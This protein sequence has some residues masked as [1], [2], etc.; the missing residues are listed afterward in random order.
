MNVCRVLVCAASCWT[1]LLEDMCISWYLCRNQETLG[2]FSGVINKKPLSA[3][4]KGS[5][6]WAR[7]RFCPEVHAGQPLGAAFTPD[8]WLTRLV[9]RDGFDLPMNALC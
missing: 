6:G 3:E 4:M 7:M 9:L 8:V 5:C 2:D 1:A